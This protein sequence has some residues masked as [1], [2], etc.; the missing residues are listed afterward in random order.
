MTATFDGIDLMRVLNNTVNYSRSYLR[1]IAT[2]QARFNSQV[3]VYVKEV[4]YKYIDSQARLYPERLA[5]VYEPGFVGAPGQRLFTL[6]THST[7][8]SITFTAR[9]NASTIATQ[10]GGIPFEQRAEMMEDDISV[11][12]APKNGKVLVFEDN[13]ETVFTTKAITI[14]HPGGPKAAGAFK[15]TIGSFFNQYLTNIVMQPIFTK[16]A[17]SKAY[18]EH[19]AE[20]TRSPLNAGKMAA[21]QFLASP[22]GVL[23]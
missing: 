5:H 13:G 2:G 16:L 22:G 20:G 8:D 19:F 15:E 17:H 3:A 23:E 7:I 21:T 4:L 9:F 18:G 12:V 14:D 1:E 6:N 11:T 10:P